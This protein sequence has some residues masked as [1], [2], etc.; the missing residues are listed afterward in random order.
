LAVSEDTH[1]RL[2]ALHARLMADWS[3]PDGELKGRTLNERNFRRIFTSLGNLDVVPILVAIDMALHD[4]ARVAASKARQAQIL[5]DSAAGE[6]FPPTFR[7]DVHDLAARL[8]RLSNQSYVQSVVQTQAIA[9][10]MRIAAT[11]FAQTESATLGSAVWRI[12][13]KDKTVQECERLWTDLVMPFLQTI[14]LEQP[15]LT[16]S[17]PRFDY[18]AMTRFENAP[19]ATPPAHLMAARP[20]GGAG[21]FL[22]SDLRKYLADLSFQ[23]SISSEGIQLADVI[24]SAFTR[25]CNGRLERR[26]WDRLGGLLTRLP[27]DRQAVSYLSLGPLLSVRPAQL[28]YGPV[29][30]RIEASAR[31]FEVTPSE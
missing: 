22:S 23:D 13:A 26:G 18:S 25:A 28:S 5:R 3:P 31:N 14:F 15:L 27:E 9:R 4:D 10:T 24:G 1:G 12:D 7:E 17:D 8:E 30:K 19:Q 11:H 29:V 20:R 2:R 16:I 6:E 21:P